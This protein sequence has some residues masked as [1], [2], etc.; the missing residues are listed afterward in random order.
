MIK[1]S[2]KALVIFMPKGGLK[3]SGGPTHSS[4]SMTLT[5]KNLSLQTSQITFSKTGVYEYQN[6]QNPRPSSLVKL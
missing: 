1:D 2:L 4:F 3:G 5:F 6:C